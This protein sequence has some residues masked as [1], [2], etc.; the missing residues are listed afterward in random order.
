M[1]TL[2]AIA[3]AIVLAIA[4][5][6][7][8]P[9]LAQSPSFAE[10]CESQEIP[11][12]AEYESNAV[13]YADNFCALA[14]YA[15]HRAAR[16]FNSMIRLVRAHDN[17]N[18]LYWD[19]RFEP[20]D[21]DYPIQL[22]RPWMIEQ[23]YGIRWLKEPAFGVRGEF[24]T[25]AFVANAIPSYYEDDW[26]PTFTL[27]IEDLGRIQERRP[28]VRYYAVYFTWGRNE[29]RLWATILAPNSR[30]YR[31]GR[32]EFNAFDATMTTQ[33][34]QGALD[35]LEDRDPVFLANPSA[36][37]FT[38]D[39]DTVFGDGPARGLAAYDGETPALLE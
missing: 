39:F 36:C 37:D 19:R 29:S 38:V 32:G 24:T 13:A 8:L 11:T 26:Q 34:V 4:L 21:W 33:G 15:P 16:Q 3:L 27:R 25:I 22:L 35:C 23:G 5:A 2:K 17:P 9:S 7:A 31:F 14:T 30:R 1:A 12:R 18:R 6:L 10:V 28:T 20:D